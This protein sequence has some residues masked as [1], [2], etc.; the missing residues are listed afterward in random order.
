MV[1]MWPSATLAFH[2]HHEPPALWTAGSDILGADCL[3]VLATQLNGVQLSFC[4][5][6]QIPYFFCELSQ[7]V[8]L[9]SFDNILNNIMVYFAAVL[10]GGGPFAGI[11]YSYSK[12]VSCTCKISSA[13]GTNKAFS[14]CPTSRLSSYFT[15]QP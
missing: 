5:G 4:T 12:I 6:V 7:V 3:V 10:M 2:G 9:A 1:V 8:P 15:L 14:V 11:L 13:L